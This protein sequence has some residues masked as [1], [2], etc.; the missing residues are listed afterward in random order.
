MLESCA[1]FATYERSH[2][3]NLKIF[4][5]G[6]LNLQ[7]CRVQRYIPIWLI[8]SGS[9]STFMTLVFIIKSLRGKRKKKLPED[10]ECN[11]SYSGFNFLLSLFEFA[12]FIVGNKKQ[13]IYQTRVLK[14]VLK[15][16]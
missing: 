1:I 16:S 4:I 15:K 5:T 10:Q 14:E 6:S 9:V 12:W 3:L 7:E 13:F 2:V 11:F 8:V